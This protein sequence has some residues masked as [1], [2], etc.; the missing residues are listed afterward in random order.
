MI[1][2]ADLVGS[3]IAGVLRGQ[4]DREMICMLIGKIAIAINLEQPVNK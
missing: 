2:P 4:L 3:C 1:M